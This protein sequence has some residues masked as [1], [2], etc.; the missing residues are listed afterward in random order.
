MAADFAF[1]Q[2][3]YPSARAFIEES[4]AIYRELGQAGRPGLAGKLLQ[5]GD[6]WR[7]SGNYE[8]AFSLF[9]EGLRIMQE[10]N[11]LNGQVT[12]LWQL[13]YYYVSVGDLRQAEE[14]FTEAL[15]LSRQTGDVYSTS[16]TL[17]GLAETAVRQGDFDARGRI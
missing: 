17:S 12:A 13:G 11:D 9:K 10:L 3:D 15:P 5:L 6:M 7:Q 14:Y 8:K 16:V 1:T 2:T 4:I